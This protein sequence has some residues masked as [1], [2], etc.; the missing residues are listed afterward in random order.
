MFYVLFCSALVSLKMPLNMN[1]KVELV[2]KD[3]TDRVMHLSLA[4]AENLGDVF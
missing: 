1:R 4:L 2:N 3:S